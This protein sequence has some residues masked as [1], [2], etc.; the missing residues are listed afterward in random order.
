MNDGSEG[1]ASGRRLFAVVFSDLRVITM[2]ET[3][4]YL[5]TCFLTYWLAYLLTYLLTYL[6]AYLL[7]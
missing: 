6:L 7:T 5:L 2:R 3:S 4:T 1:K